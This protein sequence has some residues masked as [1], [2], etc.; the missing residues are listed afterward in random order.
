MQNNQKDLDKYVESQLEAYYGSEA[1]DE[2]RRSIPDSPPPKR[3]SRYSPFIAVI[4]AAV[5]LTGAAMF[6]GA[7]F[8]G[9]FSRSTSVSADISSILSISSKSEITSSAPE[10]FSSDSN[11][12]NSV[13]TLP[14]FFSSDSDSE[15]KESSV[16]E[17][18]SSSSDSENSVSSVSENFSSSSDIE[19]ISSH[20]GSFSL[21]ETADE[22]GYVIPSENIVTPNNSVTTGI[23][24]RAG[25]G[26]FLML[27]SL[28]CT[29]ML[30]NIYTDKELYP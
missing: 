11:S 26:I 1:L 20:R 30:Y 22:G 24:A 21:P 7:V 14:E 4:C 10:I 23:K 3:T 28:C 27:S 17:N 19:N 8:T 16:S 13:S 9:G 18:F 2:L 12:E 5:F 29:A 25:I 15:N 6:T